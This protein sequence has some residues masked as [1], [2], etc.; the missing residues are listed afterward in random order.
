MLPRKSVPI[1][2]VFFMLQRLSLVAVHALLQLR[3]GG[4]MGEVPPLP[5]PCMKSLKHKYKYG[6]SLRYY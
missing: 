3:E 6:T 5:L 4:G 1:S 2:N